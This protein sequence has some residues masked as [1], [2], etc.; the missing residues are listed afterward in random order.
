[1]RKTI[2]ITGA[3]SGIGKAC[4]ELL[5]KNYDL[6]LCSRNED[7]LKELQKTLQ[8][9]G[10]K[11]LVFKLDVRSDTEVSSLFNTLAA[12]CVDVDVLINSVG[13]ALGLETLDKSLEEDIN[14]MIDTNIKGL[15]FMS[16]HALKVMKATDKGHIINLGSIA[17]IDSYPTGIT[18]AATKSAVKSISDGL[19]KDVIPNN[20]R[21]TN[22]QPGLVETKFSVIRFYGDT[23]KAKSVYKGI[24][25]LSANDIASIIKY[26]IELPQHVQI[27][28]ITVTP[29]HQATVE[30]IYRKN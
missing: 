29:T 5:A 25:P 8:A 22:I 11:V 19:R 27:N 9:Y 6:I 13:L 26:A 17:G 3:S 16:K 1:M 15:L 30:H 12:E 14:A 7:K 20:I 23:K 10:N 18:Y 21:I 4:A 2:I 24:K 28:E